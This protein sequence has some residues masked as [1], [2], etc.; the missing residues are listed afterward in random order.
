MYPDSAVEV[1]NLNRS[2]NHHQRSKLSSS[3]D[4]TSTLEIES[5]Y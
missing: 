1:L 5:R 4:Q 3:I 2:K